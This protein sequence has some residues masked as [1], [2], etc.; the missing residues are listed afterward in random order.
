MN[1][2]FKNAYFGKPYK[3]RDGRKAVYSHCI[4]NK[5]YLM[6]PHY[7]INNDST[8]VNYE[9]VDKKGYSYDN[10][11]LSDD[12]IVSEW[13]EEISEEELDKLAETTVQYDDKDKILYKV[14]GEYY[15]AD[16]LDVAFKAGYRERRNT[17][18]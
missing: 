7:Y 9:Y 16:D 8:Y 15:T 3:T 13:Q 10:Q 18:G 1:N 14:Q 6:Y 2:I 12:D 17:C 4:D 11:H 5:I